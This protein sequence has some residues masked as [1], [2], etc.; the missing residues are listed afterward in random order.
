MHIQQEADVTSDELSRN[1]PTACYRG[2]AHGVTGR[3]GSLGAGWDR[4]WRQVG[5]MP[6]AARQR[7]C[8]AGD[9]RLKMPQ[10]AHASDKAGE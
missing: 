1:A 3:M 7:Q 4:R 5:T 8:R 6:D 2:R 10:T 9:R